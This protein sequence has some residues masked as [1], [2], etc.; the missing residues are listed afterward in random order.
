MQALPWMVWLV[1]QT[2]AGL[3][4]GNAFGNSLGNIEVHERNGCFAN[5]SQT[6][7][8]VGLDIKVLNPIHFS[9]MEE[10][11]KFASL[12]MKRSDIRSLT[13]IANHARERKILLSRLTAMLFRDD[14]VDLMRRG[15][16]QLWHQTIFATT[17]CS[18]DNKPSKFNWDVSGH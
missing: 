15:T 17:V 3:A 4:Q 1:L 8:L 10:S 16:K 5:R 2:E 6:E 18:L 11:K 13:K 12:R 7:N 14:V 9:R